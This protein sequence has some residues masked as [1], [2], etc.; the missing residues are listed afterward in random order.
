MLQIS[1]ITRKAS[2]TAIFVISIFSAQDLRA[3]NDKVDFIRDIRPI[4][5]VH[6]TK[7][8]GS[9]KHEGGLRLDLKSLA[10]EGGDSG[11]A[12]LAGQPADSDL[13]DRV[14][15]TDEDGR[16]PPEGEPLSAK[17]IELLTRW[18]K[19]GA[20]WP[21]DVGV[22]QLAPD[23][24]SFKRIVPPQ[25]P[26][27]PERNPIDR[28]V[29]ARLEKEGIE[30]SGEASRHTLLR[31]LSLD[32]TGL[33]P[34]VDEIKQFTNDESPKAYERLVNR[35]LESPHFGERWSMPWLDLARYADSDGYEKDLPR[36]HAWRW[37]DWLIEAINRDLPFD[38]FTVQQL[39][40]DLLPGA[41]DEVKLATGFHR[42]TLTNREGGVDAEEFRVKA[43]IDRN[44]TTFSVW[45]G[46]TVGCAQCHS[47]K[48]D[49][50][51]QRDFYSLYAF[52]NDTNEQDL[53]VKPSASQIVQHEQQLAE[54]NNR[55]TE[56]QA[57]L[58]AERPKLNDR[59]LAWENKQRAAMQDLWK[60]LGVAERKT[61]D[62]SVVE[63]LAK[64]DLASVTA[65]RL[66]VSNAKE[67][68]EISHVAIQA[69]PAGKTDAGKLWL[70]RAVAEALGSTD[71]SPILDAS[72]ES[73]W[74][75]NVSTSKVASAIF[76][77]GNGPG[78]TG[79]LGNPPKN[80]SQDSATNLLNI[81]HQSPI[82]GR[83]TIR[84]LRVFT[85]AQANATFG[86]YLFRREGNGH[87]VVYKQ[88]F[89]ADGKHGEK[90]YPLNPVWKVL[91]GDVFAHSGNGGPTFGGGNGTTDQ[92]YYPLKSFP[93]KDAIVDLGKLPKFP[94][95][96][97]AMQVHFEPSPNSSDEA[98]IKPKWDAKGA[99]L[100]FR[101]KLA[102]GSL[103]E[104][105]LAAT[106]QADPLDESGGKL[107]KVIVKLVRDADGSRSESQRQTLFQYFVTIDAAGKKLKK[108]IDDH[109]KKKPKPPESLAHVMANANPRQTHV[110]V[111]GDSKKKGIEVQPR[112]PAFLP[113]LKF[114]ENRPDR[115]DLARW[116]VSEQNPLTSRVA[117]NQIWASLFGHGL[118]RT[119]EDF[120]TQGESPSHPEL[121]DWLA[122]EFPRLNWSRKELIKLIVTSQTYRQSSRVRKDLITKD[123]ENRL[124]A[125][126][127]R[128]R[129]E[130]ELVR[131]HYLA[132]A[133]IL[134]RKVGG[135]SFRP[136]L[137]DSV[138]RV[139]F[140]NKWTADSGDELYRR[141]MYIH[142]QRNMMLPMLTT[143]DR[144]E[145]I[146]SCTRRDRSNTPLQ[147][148]TLL[149][150][151][152]FVESARA[153]ATSV[154]SDGKLD[155]AKRIEQVFLR[156]VSRSPTSHEIERVQQLLNDVTDYYAEHLDSAQSLVGKPTEQKSAGMPSQRMAAWIAVCR[157]LLNLDES[158]TRE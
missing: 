144:P 19:Q 154:T 132:A 96:T 49:P 116:I 133:E 38:Q 9:E 63:I 32:L 24:W 148:L 156:V 149:N 93:A 2:V 114:G 140:V 34:T 13:L 141:G 138:I 139:Q 26:D 108:Q 158:I 130:A 143:F 80:G 89:K 92:I 74:A 53:K 99:T 46:L 75:P 30:P 22:I 52:F 131:D 68:F 61:I 37:R 115:L 79:W 39:A 58:D 67:E 86:A 152:T 126:Q 78:E 18:I 104:V 100:T 84:K 59:L 57:Q 1:V 118:V 110:H 43:T 103:G 65:I 44:N 69:N 41:T 20:A 121:L 16:M 28:F 83:G 135:R 10:L 109:K 21:D 88:E 11:K 146:L 31:R 5:T 122:S 73:G 62:D 29:R 27:R 25:L 95:R 113:T 36:P 125:R 40:G 56:L 155:D 76:Q 124:L 70:G 4:F 97:Y 102:K 64:T 112:T 105:Q 90:E 150:G 7:C 15:S 151:P 137:P 82:T 23:H 35:L 71:I 111:R 3:F 45:M 72:S 50:I 120:G 136:P 91:P 12:I 85:M 157:I 47:H 94:A 98:Y 123:P 33:P 117:V 42:N 51:T 60:P 147:A 106:D 142:L 87:R 77:T 55:Q 17:E 6:C 153:L 128:F 101:F 145:A 107:P 48:Y 54:H 127:N 134:N 81:F 14:S 66:Q 119:T 8:H 129:L